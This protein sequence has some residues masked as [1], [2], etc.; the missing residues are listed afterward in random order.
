MENAITFKALG[1]SLEALADNAREHLRS[2]TELNHS[3]IQ[4]YHDSSLPCIW[5]NTL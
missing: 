5:M 1:F 3:S 4:L 2:L